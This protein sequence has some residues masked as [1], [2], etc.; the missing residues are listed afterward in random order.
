MLMTCFT[1]V[2]EIE[3]KIGITGNNTNELIEKASTL[4][5]EVKVWEGEIYPLASRF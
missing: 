3:A 1:K 4:A 2:I 5:A